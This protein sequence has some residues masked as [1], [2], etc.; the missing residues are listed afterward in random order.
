MNIFSLLLTA[1]LAAVSYGLYHVGVMNEPAA[2]FMLT[3][4]LLGFLALEVMRVRSLHPQ[5]WVLNPVVW[6]S[7]HTFFLAYGVSNVLFLFPDEQLY[8]LGLVPD[9]TPP[10]VKHMALVLLAAMAMWVGYW[11]PIAAWFA[12]EKSAA[13]FQARFLPRQS[14]L[15]SLTLPALMV[16]ASGARLMQIQLGVF[17]YSSTYERLVEAGAYT[18]FLSMFASIGK[19]ALLLA[20]LQYFNNPSSSFAR[21][22]LYGLILLEVGWGLMSGFKS[23]VVMPIILAMVAQY[24]VTGRVSRQLTVFA[25]V[26]VF[27]AYA[28]IEPFRGARNDDLGHRGTTFGEIAS[29]LSKGLEDE[30]VNTDKALLP[31]TILARSNLTWIGSFGLEYADSGQ[32]GASAPEFLPNIILAPLHA[33]IPRA[34][35]DS[36]PLGDIGLWYNQEVMGMSHFSSTAMGPVTYLNF[37]GGGVA[38]FLGFFFMGCVQRIL[39]FLLQ[40]WR[41][42]QGAVVFLGMLGTISN[43]DSAFNGIVVSL[44]RELPIYLAALFL[45]FRSGSAAVGRAAVSRISGGVQGK[46]PDARI[47]RQL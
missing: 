36:K 32:V 34:I 15:R 8:L 21:F 47:G 33:W 44:V 16:I 19:A 5:C 14:H 2:F 20:A 24:L 13:A 1:A 22:W 7:F 25:V 40:P 3:G 12:R 26:A 43:I 10:M 35:W 17:G 28:V 18:Q 45:V 39:F 9:I 41:S 29:T 37:A 30:T 46:R 4:V 38:V 23:A 31:L 6:G 27:A 11:S 42:M